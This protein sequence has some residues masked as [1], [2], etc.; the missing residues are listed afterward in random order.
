MNIN[1]KKE[2]IKAFCNFINTYAG[3]MIIRGGR[4]YSVSGK[5]LYEFKIETA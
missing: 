5:L 1:M 3:E 4:I 2:A